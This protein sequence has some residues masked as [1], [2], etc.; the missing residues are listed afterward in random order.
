MVK[1]KFLLIISLLVVP[2]ITAGFYV[3]LLEVKSKSDLKETVQLKTEIYQLKDRIALLEVEL[4]Q[5]KA[6]RESALKEITDLRE[7]LQDLDTKQSQSIFPKEGRNIGF[8]EPIRIITKG[9]YY[10]PAHNTL[11]SVKKAVDLGVYGIEV[12]IQITEDHI[13]VLS[14][15][16]GYSA[17]TLEETLKFLKAKKISLLII[18]LYHLSYPEDI[19][20]EE[21]LSIIQKVISKNKAEDFAVIQTSN[22]EFL[23]LI[24]LKKYKVSWNA[25]EVQNDY[26]DKI[27]FYT[28][29]PSWEIT[30][31]KLREIRAT[32][33][34]VIGVNVAYYDDPL[35]E[36]KYYATSI[37][38]GLKYI[39]VDFVEQFKDYSKRYDIPLYGE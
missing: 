20:A 27:D 33:A 11:E 10:N 13:P 31:E 8:F 22:L 30:P 9:G 35:V 38:L 16:P 26:K 34:E 15:S 37:V 36:E 4:V 25:F 5:L 21:V 19:K 3:G 2:I 32:G 23:K 39:M 29:N 1:K 7:N 14:G 28:L 18:D 6:E 24:D 12:D 17:P